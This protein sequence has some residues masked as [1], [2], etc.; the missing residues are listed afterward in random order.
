MEF[1]VLGATRSGALV[2][3]YGVGNVGRVGWWDL[4]G[5]FVWPRR[6]VSAAGFMNVGLTRGFMKHCRAARRFC[7]HVLR[8]DIL[9][10][11]WTRC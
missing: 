4:R 3:I 6:E 1:F 2:R 10:I 9:V 5:K 11:G 8:A 7:A